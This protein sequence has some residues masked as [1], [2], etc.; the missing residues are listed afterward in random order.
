MEIDK[1]GN[2]S[3]TSPPSTAAMDAEI[4]RLHG[5]G[6]RYILP[7]HFVDNAIGDTAVDKPLYNIVNLRENQTPFSIGCALFS[8]EIGFRWP[9]IPPILAPFLLGGMVF[10]NPP[11]CQ[12]G[13]TFLGHVNTRSTNGLTTLGDFAVRAMMRRGIIVDIDHMSDRAA[14]RTLAIA[15]AVPGGGYPVTSGHAGIRE[16]VN[17]SFNAETARST[18]QLA[19]IAC[20]GGMFGMGTDAAGAH[21]WAALYDGGYNVMRR[22]F[23]PNGLCPSTLPLGAGFVALGTDANSLVKTPVPSILDPLGPPRFVDIYNASHPNNAGV[24]PLT[25]STT[26][27][28]TWDYNTDGVAHY[29]MFV[30]FL[31]DVRW[32]N[33]PGRMPGREMVDDQMMYGADYF[34]QMWLK[35]DAQKTRVPQ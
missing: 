27:T 29:G 10:P 32:F 19:R 26:G 1:I 9:G 35:A 30:D 21:R 17:P 34:Y 6:V 22:A 24:P 5:L 3:T 20:L 15:N 33:Q 2:F 12:P 14:N 8:N 16:R 7:I 23:A 28:R 13:G 18:A 4:D 11:A 31:R 25:R